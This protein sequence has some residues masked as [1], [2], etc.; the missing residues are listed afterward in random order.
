MRKVVFVTSPGPLFPVAW[1]SKPLKVLPSTFPF[2][3]PHPGPKGVELWSE[4]MHVAH[5]AQCWHPRGV[6]EANISYR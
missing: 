2:V 1:I 5:L 6:Q 3:L 4:R